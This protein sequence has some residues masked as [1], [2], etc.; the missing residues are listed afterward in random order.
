M[1]LGSHILQAYLLAGTI[2][3]QAA[4]SNTLP[5]I[6]DVTS[7]GTPSAAEVDQLQ[8]QLDLVAAATQ[9]TPAQV[10]GF[11]NDNLLSASLPAKDTKAFSM[12]RREAEPQIQAHDLSRK[13]L[14]DT[15]NLMRNDMDER[16]EDS[17]KS[18]YQEDPRFSPE[19]IFANKQLAP[20]VA[21]FLGH[22]AQRS[23]VH[24]KEHNKAARE[25]GLIAEGKG[26]VR[27]PDDEDDS[28]D[29]EDMKKSLRSVPKTTPLSHF[30]DKMDAKSDA[31]QWTPD[32]CKALAKNI[33]TQY[34]RMVGRSA[35]TWATTGPAGNAG[36]SEIHTGLFFRHWNLKKDMVKAAARKLRL[37]V[38]S[39]LATQDAGKVKLHIW[40]DLDKSDSTISDMLGPIARHPEFM[41]AINITTFDPKA[42]FA[43]VPVTLARDV[44]EERF[45]KNTMPELRPDLYRSVILYNY[46][47]LW[48]DADTVLM[49]DVAP[50][51]GEDW[52]YLVKGKEG[53]IDGALLAASRPQSH[54][55]NAYLIG[56]VMHDEPLFPEAEKPTSLLAEIFAGDP[57]HTIMHVLPPC[58][59]DSDSKVAP[60]TAVLSSDAATGS[61]FFGQPV[62]EAYH[63]YFSVGIQ[64]AQQ[65]NST[66][67]VSV[68]QDSSFKFQDAKSD[69]DD[70]DDNHSP[71][72]AYHWRGNFLAPWARGSLADVAERT[73]IHKLQLQKHHWN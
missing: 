12:L 60:E 38:L 21:E 31:A 5:S 23:R 37:G 41:D 9:A 24:R 50:L 33:T 17:H 51:M 66:A 36:R 53:A 55:S 68:L 57:V 16:E 27:N 73:F 26:R 6:S 39:F 63:K 8:N 54:F 49:Q 67:E 69:D 7:L 35:A 10:Q 71:V 46:G 18:V 48:M 19:A 52:A 42:E 64:D 40:T 29:I 44:L 14:E 20:E 56:V 61:D 45:K 34:S 43:K 47:G 59:L 65:D 32:E 30:F 28:D 4:A 15:Q 72:W 22:L 25:A 2:A 62:A 70:D 11:Q 58:F 3:L 13:I 1:S